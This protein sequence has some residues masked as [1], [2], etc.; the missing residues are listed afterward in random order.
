[1]MF[2]HDPHPADIRQQDI[3]EAEEQ[4]RRLQSTLA[5]HE[6]R[7]AEIVG[8]GEGER[9]YV[10]ATAAS[11]GQ[12][13]AV[14]LDPRAVKDGSRALSEQILLAVQRARQDALRQADA[15][16]QEALREALPGTTI[17]LEALQRQARSLLD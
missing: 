7:L 12:V 11:D 14:V 16:L 1:M 8:T 5:D 3:D 17:D 6:E 10:R 13:I 9:G 2:G 4:L 15:L